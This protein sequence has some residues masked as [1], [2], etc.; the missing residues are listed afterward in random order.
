VSDSIVVVRVKTTSGRCRKEVLSEYC[1]KQV[2]KKA[3]TEFLQ[4]KGCR[5]QVIAK[6][7]DSKT[8]GVDCRSTD[9]ILCDWCIVSLR[10][11]R[12]PGQEH[13]ESTD[14]YRNEVDSEIGQEASNEV[15]GSEMIA[16]KLQELVEADELVFQ[17]MDILKG[18]CI[19]CEFVPIDGGA[20]EE[21]HTYAECFP[22][23]ANQVGY[24]G[25]QKWQENLDFGKEFRYCFDCGLP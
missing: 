5:R 19:Y 20:K 7:F 25:F 21:P 18:G 9:S 1:V 14:K 16:G 11:P 13:E 8:K 6:H 10:R 24:Q 15:R 12:A 4:V 17:T 3:I 23:V 2:D 22:A